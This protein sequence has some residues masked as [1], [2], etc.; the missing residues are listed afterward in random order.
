[1][2]FKAT[3]KNGRFWDDVKKLDSTIKN[4]S[5]NKT[6][7]SEREFEA[8]FSAI[9]SHEQ[10]SFNCEVISQTDGAASVESVKCMG[11][12]YRPD[13]TLDRDGV[14]VELKHIKYDGLKDAI[15]QAY[16][17]RLKYRFVFL[18]LIISKERQSVYEELDKEQDLK[19][20][21]QH[22]ADNMKIFTY[23]VPAFKPKSGTKK[24][25]SFFEPLNS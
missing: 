11:K 14:A 24:C 19:D 8:A 10:S 5:F 2:G 20:A 3:K 9:L 22:L 17:Y 16:L 21:L 18:V 12:N 4:T 6:F 13:L 15:G 1:M 23:I 7:K 25:Y